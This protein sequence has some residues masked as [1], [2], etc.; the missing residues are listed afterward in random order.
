MR[1]NSFCF[2][3]LTPFF[4]SFI[5]LPGI[6]GE[7]TRYPNMHLVIRLKKT[8]RLKWGTISAQL[9]EWPLWDLEVV[10]I[11]T[12][13]LGAEEE[14][15]SGI[16]LVNP[17][18]IRSQKLYLASSTKTFNLALSVYC[19]RS[20]VE[21]LNR[22]LKTNF[23]LYKL[24]LLSASRL[25]RMWILLS[26]AFYLSF[27]NLAIYDYDFVS[28]ISRSY[29]DGRRDLSWLSLSK[30]AEL[31]GLFDFDFQPLSSQ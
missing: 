12:A 25:E 13:T 2:F 10:E 9:H 15:V 31:S 11:E 3:P 7:N 16:C 23:K 8:T 27:S 14:V 20:W 26:L 1:E 5:F 24:H 19:K 17:G 30:F 28:R 29:K 21:Q 22:D 18:E 6:A 4:T